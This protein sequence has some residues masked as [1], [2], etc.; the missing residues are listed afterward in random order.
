MRLRVEAARQRQVWGHV[1]KAFDIDG[2][3]NIS[4]LFTYTPEDYAKILEI[5]E[6]KSKEKVCANSQLKR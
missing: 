5:A 3:S 2:V 6:K 1:L 4:F